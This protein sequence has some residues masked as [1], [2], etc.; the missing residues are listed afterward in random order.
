MMLL[1][2]LSSI[3]LPSS[4]KTSCTLDIGND[5]DIDGAPNSANINRRCCAAFTPP[6]PPAE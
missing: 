1:S 6:K 2:Y 4:S 3:N 5:E